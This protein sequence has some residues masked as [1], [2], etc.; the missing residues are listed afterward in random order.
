M[1]VHLVC[2]QHRRVR[3]LQ[4]Q[5]SA[6]NARLYHDMGDTIRSSRQGVLKP[7]RRRAVVD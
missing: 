3:P 4:L 7:G 5:Q 6:F 2:Q 1:P